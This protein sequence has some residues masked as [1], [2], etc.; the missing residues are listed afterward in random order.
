VAWP[1]SVVPIYAEHWG[2]LLEG[3]KRDRLKVMA[4]FRYALFFAQTTNLSAN[5]L[6]YRQVSLYFPFPEF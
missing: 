2:G 3:M 6:I 4:L 1:D 5:L